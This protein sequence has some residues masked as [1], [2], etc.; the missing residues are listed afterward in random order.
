MI[1]ERTIRELVRRV[2]LRTVEAAAATGDDD[3][4]AWLPG[5]EDGSAPASHPMTDR[6]RR[7]GSAVTACPAP[8]RRI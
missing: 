6:T 4:T 3:E 2:V 7:R 1:D 8:I 5:N